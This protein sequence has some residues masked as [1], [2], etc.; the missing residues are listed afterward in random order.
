MEDVH[1][2][3]EE[4]PDSGNEGKQ[5]GVKKIEATTSVWSKKMLWVIF[6]M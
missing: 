3:S 1:D 6:A 2:P 4:Q 5:A